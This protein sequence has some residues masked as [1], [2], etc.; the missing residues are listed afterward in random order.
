MGYKKVYFRIRCDYSN[1]DGWHGQSPRDA[2]H[3][4][5]RELFQTDG[6][7][8]MPAQSSGGCATVTKG[9]QDLYLHPMNFSGVIQV[10]EIPHLQELFSKAETFQCYGVDQYEDFFDLSDEE[11]QALLEAQRDKIVAA[12]LE[13]CRTK[14]KNLYVTAHAVLKVAD[15]FIVHRLCDKD[16]K[17][18]LAVRYVHNIIEEMIRDGRLDRAQLKSGDGF[19]TRPEKELQ[20]WQSTQ[21]TGAQKPPSSTLKSN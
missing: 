18:N 5:V 11:Y 2:F 6:W 1:T 21:Q 14:R 7:Q 17:H 15:R 3:M 9:W 4:E 13:Q 10:E 20:K 8:Y 16:G 19:R 12:V